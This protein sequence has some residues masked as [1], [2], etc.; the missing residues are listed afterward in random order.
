MKLRGLLMTSDERG[1]VKDILN[2][3]KKKGCYVKWA[4]NYSKTNIA[5]L[6][7]R[8]KNSIHYTLSI[9]YN[10]KSKEKRIVYCENNHLVPYLLYLDPEVITLLKSIMCYIKSADDLYEI[11]KIS[12]ED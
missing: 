4:T 3:L 2:Q 5:Y 1:Y 8:I 11:G 6:E 12:K 10:I 9:H 7:F